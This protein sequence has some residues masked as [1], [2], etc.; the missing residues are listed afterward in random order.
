MDFPINVDVYCTDGKFGK[1]TAL[2]VDPTTEKVSFIAVSDP[3]RIYT[4]YLVPISGIA[5]VD[6]S[7][8]ELSYSKAEVEKLEKFSEAD[9]LDIPY[10]G[11]GSLDGMSD[12]AANIYRKENDPK[13]FVAVSKGM[14]VEATDG[15]VGNVD[16]LVID[17]KTG[18]VTHLVMHTGHIWG[19]AEVSIPV[20]QIKEIDS[21]TVYLDRDK[22][23]IETLPAVQIRRHYSR[24][25]INQLEIEILIWI[26]KAQNQ[27][28]NAIEHLKSYAKERSI[29]LRNIAILEKDTEGKTKT[30]EVADL[31]SRKGGIT[32]LIAGGL[33]G[34]LAGPGGMILGAAAGAATGGIAAKKIDLGFSNE[35]LAKLE[36]EMIPGSSVIVTLVETDKAQDL[37]TAMKSFNGQLYQQKVNE[38]IISELA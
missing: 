7:K 10:Y 5:N 15:F 27:A 38:E 25:E 31:G 33:I 22:A 12:M 1:T 18:V 11:Y 34:L 14:A 9:F 32:G 36:K 17:P 24:K 8:I 28:K 19:S 4:E 21:L 20:Y 23:S 16:E 13:G 6:E 37:I 30:S 2:I 29:E 3:E 35:Y 26:F